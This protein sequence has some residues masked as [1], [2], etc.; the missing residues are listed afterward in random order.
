[1]T[2]NGVLFDLSTALG[3]LNHILKSM[4]DVKVKD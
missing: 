4:P 1:M 2:P 3:C